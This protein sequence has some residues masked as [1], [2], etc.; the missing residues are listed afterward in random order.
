MSTK[1]VPL[2]RPHTPPISPRAIELFEYLMRLPR[3]VKWTSEANEIEIEFE[4][5]FKGA[6][7]LTPHPVFDCDR[8]EPPAW[9]QDAE[10][11]QEWH[12]SRALR[13]QLEAALR[14]RR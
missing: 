10:K 4:M 9:E 8:P 5:L 13:L 7:I 1:R 12:Q 3:P 14:T 2:H 11:I 6:G